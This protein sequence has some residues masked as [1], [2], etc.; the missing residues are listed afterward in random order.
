MAVA[1]TDRAAV[2]PDAA[3]AVEL[4]GVYKAFVSRGGGDAAMLALEDV[5]FEGPTRLTNSP[6]CASNETSSRASIAASRPP[7]ETNAL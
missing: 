4:T 5:S 7:R 6:G 2:R 1:E 3:P